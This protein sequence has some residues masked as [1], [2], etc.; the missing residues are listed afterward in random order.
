V[1]ILSIGTLVALILA[2]SA[3]SYAIGRWKR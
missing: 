2:V 1:I 3:I